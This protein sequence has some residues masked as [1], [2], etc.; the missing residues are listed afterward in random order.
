MS[1]LVGVSINLA[2]FETKKYLE[3]PHIDES[4]R[5]LFI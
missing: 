4:E 3:E 2:E 1:Y 5:K